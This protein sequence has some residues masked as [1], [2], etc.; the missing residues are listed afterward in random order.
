MAD[1]AAEKRAKR[2]R[3]RKRAIAEVLSTEESYVNSLGSLSRVFIQPLMKLSADPS[4][5][6]LSREEIQIIFSNIEVIRQLNEKFKEDLKKEI[7]PEGTE[8]KTNLGKTFLEFSQFFK[9]Y[10]MY[11]NNYDRAVQFLK[12]AGT[13]SRYSDFAQSAI[14]DP[15]CKQPSLTSYLIMPIQRIPRYKM[16]LEEVIK[17]TEEGHESLPDLTKAVDA[18]A[19]VAKHINEEVNKHK[20]REKILEIETMFQGKVDL[21][22]PTRVFIRHGVLVKKCRASNRVYEFFLFNNLVVYA[23]NSGFGKLKLHRKIEINNSFFIQD[24][25]DKPAK[26]AKEEP[27]SN[28]FQ[29]VSASKSFVVMAK[30]AAEKKSWFD[31][32]GAQVDK[33]KTTIPG[34][35]EDLGSSLFSG[36]PAPVWQSDHSS[37]DCQLCHRK[38]TMF[39]RRHH[40]RFCGELVCNNCSL[41]RLMVPMKNNPKKKEARRICD[42]CVKDFKDQKGSRPSESSGG[43]Q[44]SNSNFS[45][46]K[47]SSPIIKSQTVESV[48]EEP[49]EPT[50]TAPHAPNTRATK[51]TKKA[52]SEQSKCEE[53]TSAVG[54][55][56]EELL[57][58][59]SEQDAVVMLIEFGYTA[60]ADG[61]LSIETGDFIEVLE[62]SPNGWWNGKLDSGTSGW[63][64]SSY[65]KVL[66]RYQSRYSYKGEGE[67]DLVFEEG[68]IVHVVQSGDEGW[69]T[70]YLHGKIGLFPSN[71]FVK[72]PPSKLALNNQTPRRSSQA[73]SE[74]E[75]ANKPST[76]PEVDKR[77]NLKDNTQPTGLPDTS[78]TS[79]EGIKMALS[80]GGAGITTADDTSSDDEE[81]NK[82]VITRLKAANSVG[83]DTMPPDTLRTPPKSPL[84]SVPGIKWRK[85]P[86]K[87]KP[88]QNRNDITSKT[89][90]KPSPPPPL[91]PSLK[92]TQRD[93][94][95]LEDPDKVT[96]TAPPKKEKTSGAG[97]P[98]PKAG[99]PTRSPR[100]SKRPP[101]P[102]S[103]KKPEIVSPKTAPSRKPKPS[104]KLEVQA[105]TG[106]E[107]KEVE[108][109]KRQAKIDKLKKLIDSLPPFNVKALRAK[110]QLAEVLAEDDS[111]RIKKSVYKRKKKKKWGAGSPVKNKVGAS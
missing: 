6:I 70:G 85:R 93:S 75:T 7:G 36:G 95:K 61:E 27:E 110:A 44:T 92:G 25:P 47:S 41:K 56:P 50:T 66:D 96:K 46:H 55:G 84:P 28:R 23:S 69:W 9:M 31:D 33:L 63:F 94:K 19:K 52:L 99:P 4:Q 80:N 30:D 90:S 39:Y 29:I 62:M 83:A 107:G 58:E 104:S 81:E 97:P 32:F 40:C 87:P 51:S 72:L 77:S 78:A 76:E 17:N 100:Q 108:G 45:A 103:R 8:E 59:K 101:G 65:G 54:P 12:T 53:K 60:D 20:N 74:G 86:P 2:V 73:A 1:K 57:V 98:L 34:Q 22:A 82:Q 13:R 21:V 79:L 68:D 71:F 43:S 106:S 10:T 89:A 109:S 91:K 24:L 102:P 88:D 35:K 26:S 105:K 3:N 18:I 14:Q 5:M 64:P 11:V 38:F 111:E 49:S 15:D 48:P 16:L 37:K 42:R 67:N